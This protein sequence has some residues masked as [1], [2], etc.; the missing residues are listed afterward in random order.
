MKKSYY[1]M[2]SA[3][4]LLL[5]SFAL[6]AEDK[7]S[8][9]DW[10]QFRGPNG[11]GLSETK[12]LPQEFGPDKN[13]VWKIPL[14]PGHSSPILTEDYI[15]VTAIEQETLYTIC[16][17]RKKGSIIWQK[18]APRPRQVKIDGRNSPASP[19]P[20]TDG[21]N[22]YV[23]FP[24]FGI[25][26]Y[27]LKGT[28]LWRFPLGPFENAYGM[29]ASPIL[30]DNSV[31]LVCDQNMDSYIIAID[32][33]TGKQLWKTSRPEV[34]S[35]HS[36]P[37]IYTP[38]NGEKQVI[39]PGSFLL[40]S[41]SVNTGKKLW[42][43]SGLAFEMKSTPVILNGIVY[44]NGYTSPI[45][46]PDQQEK[47][48]AFKTAL[49]KYDKNQ[50][51]L[52][53]QAEVPKE[54]PYDWFSFVDFAGDGSLDSEDW[55]FFTAGLASL[56]GM[57][58]IKLGGQGD[59]SSSNVMWQYRRSIPQLPS[60]LIYQNVLYMLNDGGKMTTFRPDTGE[61]IKQER[62]RG[63]GSH[64]YSSPVAADNKIF[65]ISLRGKVSV[66]KPGGGLEVQ[67]LN[68]LKEKCYATPA[69]AEGK[70]Y[71]RTEKTLYCFGQKTNK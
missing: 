62:L 55:D 56:N 71:I 27:D 13:V 11:S 44:I 52:L 23:F 67:A 59:M 30:A 32:K 41:Y 45:N 22:V 35:G 65:I 3:I 20:V 36:T 63:A 5:S 69:I 6:S 17:N 9:V 51:G 68:D 40:I 29:G 15:F 31:I 53:S 39:I 61:V 1:I 37:V 16:L 19:S 43:V 7:E 10:K 14:P 66:L 18:K 34:K 24:D 28:E 25:L 4:V 50:D 54:T 47:I 8:S 26:A 21:K 49:Q 58:A 42:W 64:F 46:Q 57:L 2:L 48:P 38:K 33:R 60:P 70:L 12:G